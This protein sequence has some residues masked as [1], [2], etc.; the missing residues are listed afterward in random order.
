MMQN[1]GHRRAALLFGLVLCISASPALGQTLD[2]TDIIVV[3]DAAWAAANMT[4][5]LDAFSDLQLAIR[6][7]TRISREQR[8]RV[9]IWLVPNA[10]GAAAP[11]TPGGLDV[12]FSIPADA[13]ITL[14]G[15]ER[16]LPSGDII[17]RP[18]IT[19][20]EAAIDINT[21]P[22][23]LGDVFGYDG[24]PANRV[25]LEGLEITGGMVGV[26]IR[27]DGGA[28]PAGRDFR[29]TINR[30]SIQ[31]SQVGALSLDPPYD[32]PVL[33]GHGVCVL[34]SNGEPLIVNC[35]ITDNA[36]DGVH[37]ASTTTDSEV[38]TDVLHCSIISNGRHGVYVTGTILNTEAAALRAR[39]RNSIIYLNGSSE[40][41]DDGGLVWADGVSITPDNADI[42]GNN[43]ATGT[44]ETATILG[45]GLIGTSGT[46][47][48]FGP[49]TPTVNSPALFTMV[50]AGQG[51]RGDVP[52]AYN[53]APGTVDVH[54]IR[55]D[56]HS[57]VLREAFTYT[58]NPNT[59]NP[60]VVTN[61]EPGSGPD[62]GGNW[63]K[64][65]GARF[66]PDCQVWFDTNVGGGTDAV[67]D[68]DPIDKLAPNMT[69]LSSALLYVEAPSGPGYATGPIHVLVRNR[70]SNMDSPGGGMREYQYLL[71]GDTPPEIAQLMPNFVRRRNPDPS[72]KIDIY[73]WNFEEGCQ[74]RIG[75]LHC[76]YV[77][78]T[79]HAV[80]IVDPKGLNRRWCEINDVEVPFA[81]FGSGGLYDVE[82]TNPT[83]LY[84]IL[85][86]G[87]TYYPDGTPLLNDD[88][89]GGDDYDLFNWFP[90]NFVEYDMNNAAVI[91]RTLYGDG[92]DAGIEVVFDDVAG[93]NS[94]PL[95]VDDPLRLLD[96]PWRNLDDSVAMPDE[97][98]EQ[99]V[100]HTQRF[101]EFKLPNAPYRGLATPIGSPDADVE[102]PR[103][104][105][106]YFGAAAR[107]L[108]VSVS[109]VRNAYGADTTAAG[110]KT[111]TT[112]MHWLEPA[113]YFEITA[114]R[115]Y[116]ENPAPAPAWVEFDVTGGASLA[117]WLADGGFANAHVYVGNQEAT[118]D[119]VD[120][121]IPT[122]PQVRF[123]PALVS[124]E[125]FFG[126]KD[127][128]LVWD[129]GTPDMPYFTVRDAVYIPPTVSWSVTGRAV[130]PRVL[131]ATGGG[132]TV[133]ITGA[134]FQGPAPVPP[135]SADWTYTEAVLVY[136]GGANEMVIRQNAAAYDIFSFNEI[137]FESFDVTANTDPIPT[138]VPVDLELRTMAYSPCPPTSVIEIDSYTMERAIVFVDAPRIDKAYVYQPP[139]SSDDSVHWGPVTGGGWLAI[140]GSGFDTTIDPFVRIGDTEAALAPSTYNSSYMRVKIPPAPLG[141]PGTHDVTAV[142]NNAWK[143]VAVAPEDQ[144]YTYIMDGFPS[145]TSIS[146]NEMPVDT[147]E[148]PPQDLG[149]TVTILG[150]NFD[151]HVEVTYTYNNNV[152]G[153]VPVTYQC[154]SIS[155]TEIV[156][157]VPNY[158]DFLNPANNLGIPGLDSLNNEDELDPTPDGFPDPGIYP[159][160]IAGATLTVTVTNDVGPATTNVTSNA[161]AF[162]YVVDKPLLEMAPLM[163]DLLFNDVYLNYR[164]YVNVGPGMGSI[165]VDPMLQ[166][167]DPADDYWWLGKLAIAN[168]TDFG[169]PRRLNPMR[170]KAGK[171]IT[172]APETDA[173]FEFEPRPDRID[174]RDHVQGTGDRTVTPE[175]PDIGADE[176]VEWNLDTDYRWYGCQVTPEIVGAVGAG[177]VKIDIQ[178]YTDPPSDAR[179]DGIFVLP[180]G[181]PIGPLDPAVVFDPLFPLE[182]LWIEFGPV[183]KTGRY[184]YHATNKD[185]ITTV[186]RDVD[187]SGGPSA[188]DYLADGHAAVYLWYDNPLALDGVPTADDTF[189]GDNPGDLTDGK[190]IEED[191]I[192]GRHFLIDTTPPKVH[193]TPVPVAGVNG[194][195]EERSL[196]PVTEDARLI[197]ELNNLGA[198][199]YSACGTLVP[200]GASGVPGFGV[201]PALAPLTHPYASLP[202]FPWRPND[203]A[204]L[205]PPDAAFDDLL[206]D[207]PTSRDPKIFFNVSSFSNL[208]D[209]CYTEAL[210]I[211]VGAPDLANGVVFV[212]WPPLDPATNEFIEGGATDTDYYTL[213]T[214]REVAG[215]EET[216]LAV[217]GWRSAYGPARW[218]FDDSTEIP[219]GTELR[220]IHQTD[221]TAGG[222]V[223]FDREDPLSTTPYPN[224]EMY[225]A[226]T[227]VEENSGVP[228]I[229]GI[230]YS[231]V[232]R[233]PVHMAARFRAYDLARNITPVADTLDPLHIWWMIEAW[234]ELVPELEGLTL[235]TLPF[236]WNLDR[237]QQDDPTPVDLE[238]GPRF[239]WRLWESTDYEGQ[240]PSYAPLATGTVLDTWA[241]WASY[242]SGFELG[243]TLIGGVPLREALCDLGL[244]GRWLLLVVVGADESGNVELW[245]HAELD[246][247]TAVPNIIMVDPDH[248]TGG[249][250][251]QRFRV[252]CSP[253]PDTT[254]TPTFW[255][256]DNTPPVP[257]L[258][259][260]VLDGLD[261][262]LGALDVIPLHPGSPH[263]VGFDQPNMRIEGEFD[264]KVQ[265]P[266][267]LEA[268]DPI[269]VHW[270]L[271]R[272]GD[273]IADSNQGAA[274]LQPYVSSGDSVSVQIP[275]APEL[276][277]PPLF[278]G[279]NRGKNLDRMRDDAGNELSEVFYVFR[280]KAFV[281][282]NND[283]EWN[284]GEVADPTPANVSFKVLLRDVASHMDRKRQQSKQPIKIRELE[285]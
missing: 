189:L 190:Q 138:G 150:T 63:V 269:K 37:V 212:D 172:N 256:N 74:V 141:L 82:V 185:A 193:L 284:D 231:A 56:G 175:L 108:F 236:H 91:T 226:W 143:T 80:T 62:T 220:V 25:I 100:R 164:D 32:D 31:N 67:I 115:Q 191:A 33:T 274:A 51:I 280:A 173:D 217:R 264:V 267:A 180:Q 187:G 112:Q 2:S 71:S 253:A 68:A 50:V 277:V 87:L 208:F 55:D 148:T 59:G 3:A 116:C 153:P 209:Q 124:S 247:T 5:P 268:G 228:G 9:T 42:F 128:T 218:T 168:S 224:N 34:A 89:P 285:D 266:A 119:N 237:G 174:N 244:G 171:A 86:S 70:G 199:D 130:E 103:L 202:A 219:V 169:G 12:S 96:E 195:I 261:V 41:T 183:Q 29:P 83:G 16:E 182:P 22:P 11:W 170:D 19:G 48:Y 282:E 255:Y 49:P 210:D 114:T 276:W 69:W 246:I 66:E 249:K 65:E 265:I 111:V 178:I 136:N 135:A 243:N 120:D 28:I 84:D 45:L 163:P 222:N 109:N 160:K 204:I 104:P 230:P 64:V 125:S 57:Y 203:P 184:R 149:A 107:D 97:E 79:E 225:A 8:R 94:D 98:V 131:P 26:L 23:I 117:G 158:W 72:K 140:E 113:D 58:E 14:L 99:H 235:D 152:D 75:G 35:S 213:E 101:V 18:F 273:V 1:T 105:A 52:P 259:T 126:V 186:V 177:A 197:V 248:N 73:G 223:G 6:E 233:G 254:V 137:A 7:A 46:T 146:P 10:G 24:G 167:Q 252:Q 54:I 207:P 161:A 110:Q 40:E 179:P 166:P 134:G 154:F 281:D 257:N 123:N 17:P 270:D 165:S 245:P 227:F 151:D 176:I 53:S 127:L 200:Y 260:E 122:A 198:G 142:W 139:P 258:A 251:W 232:N 238:A 240:A 221:G 271:L 44:Q 15:I 279:A 196:A 90:A 88:Q 229:P 216:D 121:I 234:T 250:N 129:N 181:V 272:D 242:P 278:T 215:F 36:S 77:D 156:V 20:T 47:V 206:E 194:P 38:L 27:D 106:A 30:C 85:E 201:V 76:S 92:F 159:T 93:F 144:R 188:G 211:T 132:G 81:A 60:P 95:I 205:S 133:R 262:R 118:I 39:V 283:N 102:F 192:L 155:P 157:P 214:T 78:I 263:F 4:E 162:F 21:D 43:A 13:Q 239:T 147:S 61:V 241:V 275:Y 145:I